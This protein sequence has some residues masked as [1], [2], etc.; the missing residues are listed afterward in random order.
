MK[1]WRVRTCRFTPAVVL[2]FV[3]GVAVP[4]AGFVFHTHVGGD[5]FHVHADE[6]AGD[7]HDDDHE[8]QHEH[9]HHH[10]DHDHPGRAAVHHDHGAVTEHAGAAFEAPEPGHVGHWHSQH[11]FHRVV[12]AC[13]TP[14]G[15]P[16]NFVAI[17]ATVRVEFPALPLVASR[18]RAPPEPSVS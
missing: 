6:L 10:H 13:L 12:P 15:F 11:P 5:H 3:A 4:R 14:L 16:S 18:A 17:A 2:L 9:H 7:G 1:R 8:H